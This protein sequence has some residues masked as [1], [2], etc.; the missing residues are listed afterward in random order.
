[1]KKLKD[2]AFHYA[3][4]TLH[5]ALVGSLFKW[6]FYGGIIGILSGSSSALF[7][8]SLDFATN[9][10]MAY[11]WLLYLLPIGGAFMSYLYLKFGKNAGKGNNLILEQIQDGQES[12]P[13]RMAPLVLLGTFLTHL[14]GGSAGREGTAVQMGGSFSEWIG[15]VFKVD[16]IDR[17]ILLMCGISSGFGS[18]F[19]TPLAGTIFGLEVIAIGLVS[20]Q[21]II[22]CFIASFVGNLVTTAWGI[23]HIHYHMGAVPVLSVSVVLKVIF[24]SILF[25]LASILFSELTHWLKKMYTKLFKNP[26]IKG[27]VGGLV[28]IALVFIFGTRDYLG[29]GIPLL[30]QSFEEPVSR[31]AFLWKTLFTTLTLGAGFQGGEVTPLFVIGATLGNSLADLLHLS[32]P[33]LAG[34]GLIA[35]FSGA[36]NTPIACF[37]MGIELFGSEGMIYMFMA[38]IVSYLFSGHTGIYTSQQIGISKSKLYPIPDKS[39]LASIKTGKTVEKE[40]GFKKQL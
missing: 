23:H 32:P 19:G 22:P 11:S 5:V 13:F 31:L 25:G 9:K 15:K 10:R 30:Q 29:L 33:F 36:T 27:F 7:L 26:M 17:K 12:I 16:G 2:V 39:T 35:V 14:F 34:L 3:E 28:I 18:V 20:Y 40:Q 24:A 6:I 38:C 8:A 21:A 4:K 1:M 37:V